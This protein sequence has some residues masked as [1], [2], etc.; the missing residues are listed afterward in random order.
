MGSQLFSGAYETAFAQKNHAT[1]ETSNN[2]DEPNNNFYFK[3]VPIAKFRNSSLQNQ[4]C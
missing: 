3:V 4:N 1:I 2:Y